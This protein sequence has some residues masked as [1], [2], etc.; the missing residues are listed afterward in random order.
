MSLIFFICPLFFNNF[1]ALNFLMPSLTA[2]RN[3]TKMFHV[4][5]LDKT[6]RTAKALRTAKTS[7]IKRCFT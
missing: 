2:A 3:L 5:H 7:F 6:L 4:K 1:F